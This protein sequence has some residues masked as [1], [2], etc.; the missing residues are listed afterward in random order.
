MSCGAGSIILLAGIALSILSFVTDNADYGWHQALI[1]TALGIA[2]LGACFFYWQQRLWAS[3][4]LCVG[5]V[6]A[7]LAITRQALSLN[8]QLGSFSFQLV[9]LFAASIICL[10]IVIQLLPSFSRVRK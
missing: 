6:F 1:Y 7:I 10:I 4:L 9:L 8:R 5:Y 3:R 2:I